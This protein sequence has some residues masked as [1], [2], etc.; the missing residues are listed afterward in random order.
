MGHSGNGM[1]W[2]CVLTLQKSDNARTD[3]GKKKEPI[4]LLAVLGL[5]ME[6]FLLDT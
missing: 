3:G 4:I 2:H 1:S 6:V 5:L